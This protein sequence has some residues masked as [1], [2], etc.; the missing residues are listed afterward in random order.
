[1]GTIL[2][3]Q[4]ED[5]AKSFSAVL[6]KKEGGKVVLSYFRHRFQADLRRMVVIAC[7]RPPRGPV[8]PQTL[9][10]ALSRT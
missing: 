8:P 3:R 4:T 9:R 5:G 7:E 1:M 2:E 6:R 10:T